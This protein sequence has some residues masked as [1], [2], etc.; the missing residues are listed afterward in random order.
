M[1]KIIVIL[2][3]AVLI[4]S[5]GCATILGGKVDSCQRAKPAPGGQ[6]R[7]IRAGALIADI[8]LGGFIFP[9]IDFA[10]CAIYKPCGK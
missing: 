1:K 9:A 10:T 6:S 8:L 2:C 4:C 5:S 3:C 7:K